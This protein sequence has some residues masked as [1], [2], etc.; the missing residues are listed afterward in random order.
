MLFKKVKKKLNDS[1]K[2]FKTQDKSQGFGKVKH[3]FAENAS[4]KRASSSPQL[5]FVAYTF[6]VNSFLVLVA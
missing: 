1:R 6:L 3:A 2:K 4:K 5:L